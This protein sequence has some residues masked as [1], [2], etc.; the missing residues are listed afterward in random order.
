MLCLCLF[1]ITIQITFNIFMLF[2]FLISFIHFMFLDWNEFHQSETYS[3]FRNCYSRKI[4]V[5]NFHCYLGICY[6]HVDDFHIAKNE[7][8]KLLIVS[9]F[10]NYSLLF[11]YLRLY[12]LSDLLIT[13]IIYILMLLFFYR[14][15]DSFISF[16]S[17][18]HSSA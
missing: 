18:F 6:S 4:F 1:V 14:P 13:V 7:S 9:I 2:F 16:I 5:H 10:Q 3:T 17:S 8:I 15:V 11:I 12:L